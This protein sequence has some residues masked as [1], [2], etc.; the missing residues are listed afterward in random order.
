MNTRQLVGLSCDSRNFS[1][2]LLVAT[3]II[4]PEVEILCNSKIVKKIK[5]FVHKRQKKLDTYILGESRF[6]EPT[7]KYQ[8][9]KNEL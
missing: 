8:G 9:D 3:E 4:L 1:R 7:S 6:S 2:T 5:K